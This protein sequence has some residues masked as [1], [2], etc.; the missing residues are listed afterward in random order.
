MANNYWSSI[1]IVIVIQPFLFLVILKAI[2]LAQ[3][4]YI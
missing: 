2:K 4:A 3:M 1:M